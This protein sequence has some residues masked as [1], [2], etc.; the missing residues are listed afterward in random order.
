[1]S[2]QNPKIDLST[3]KISL[4]LTFTDFGDNILLNNSFG[5]FEY[6]YEEIRIFYNENTKEFERMYNLTYIDLEPC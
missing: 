5:H 2:G 1:M 4:G 3:K 6:A